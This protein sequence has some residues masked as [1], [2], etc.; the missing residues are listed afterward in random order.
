MPV[1]RRV[2]GGE[3]IWT[4][5]KRSK[6]VPTKQY[7]LD[8]LQKLKE[9]G[10]EAVLNFWLD[11]A[12][13][14]DTQDELDRRWAQESFELLDECWSELQKPAQEDDDIFSVLGITT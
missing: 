10:N 8:R 4:D 6:K 3:A 13:A 12:K 7:C 2:V 11:R 5:G 14:I 9:Q 1:F